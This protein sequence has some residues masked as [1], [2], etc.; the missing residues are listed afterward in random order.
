[1]SHL[2]VCTVIRSNLELSS[3]EI[4]Q[5]VNHEETTNTV[6]ES[7]NFTSDFTPQPRA[8]TSSRRCLNDSN[9]IDADSSSM[10][11]SSYEDVCWE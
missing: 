4:S 2:T 3:L 11:D 7:C 10:N 5:E 1:M 8:V 9:E 6:G